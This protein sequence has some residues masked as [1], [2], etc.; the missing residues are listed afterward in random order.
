MDWCKVGAMPIVVGLDCGGSTSRALATDESGKAAWRSQAGAANLATTDREVL[1]ANIRS[2]LAGCPPV[3]AVCGCFAGLLTSED[4]DAAKSLL[5]ELVPYALVRA[6]PDF[7]AA[8]WSAPEGVDVVVVAGTG[9]LVCSRDGPGWNKSGGGGYLLGDPGSGFRF[10][11]AALKH[12]LQD[13]AA[14]SG[15]LCS[16]VQRLYGTTDPQTVIART[17]RPAPAVKRIA[18][19][20]SAFAEDFSQ[21]QAYALES[22]QTELAQLAN[23]VICH[24]QRYFPGL[25][26]VTV[27]LTGGVWKIA[28]PLAKRFA[29]ELERSETARK[30]KTVQLA[31]PPVEGAAKLARQMLTT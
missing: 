31:K 11:L 17:Y 16:E 19:L 2:L 30:W 8:L 20:M 29:D 25:N 10:G 13:P 7:V 4:S 28:K 14:A 12:F 22:A 21:H 3:D 9:S 27:G 6:E 1:E 24:T 26:S 5:R 18:G 23:Q 15:H